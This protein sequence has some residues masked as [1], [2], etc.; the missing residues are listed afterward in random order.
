MK[1]VKLL[2]YFPEKKIINMTVMKRVKLLK[3]FPDQK[4]WFIRIERLYP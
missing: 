3:Y 1:R 2:K 4:I